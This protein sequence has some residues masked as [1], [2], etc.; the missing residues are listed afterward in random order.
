MCAPYARRRCI[1]QDRRSEEARKRGLPDS[2]SGEEYTDFKW[3]LQNV[4][5]LYLGLDVLTLLDL[6]YLSRFWTQVEAWFAMQSATPE[7]LRP[8]KEGEDRLT[9]HPILAAEASGQTLQKALRE[10]WSGRTC[11]QAITALRYEDIAVTNLSDKDIQIEKLERLDNE[12]KTELGGRGPAPA[13][14]RAATGGSFFNLAA[15]AAKLVA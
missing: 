12:V 4:N 7:G 13:A 14:A 8:A 6:S 11:E 2:R 15:T 10:I 5:L 1:P 9:I 3:Q